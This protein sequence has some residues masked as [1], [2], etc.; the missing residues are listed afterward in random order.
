ML[1]L[2]VGKPRGPA[3][4]LCMSTVTEI[5]SALRELPLSEVQELAQWLQKY[6]DQRTAA[7]AA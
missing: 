3:W 7:D 6:L 4:I 5:E 1:P 2:D